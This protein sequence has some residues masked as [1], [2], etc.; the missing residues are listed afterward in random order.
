MKPAPHA[1]ISQGRDGKLAYDADERGNRV[2]DFSTC[3]YAGGDRKIP[4]APVRVVVSPVNGDATARIQLAIDYIASLAPD[5]NGLRGAVLL[6]KGRYEVF[7]GLT[8]TNSGVVLRGQ[9]TEN[10]HLIAT[11]LDRRTFIRVSRPQDSSTNALVSIVG[12]VPLNTINIAVVDPRGLRP[13][14]GPIRITRQ[15]SCNWIDQL[16]TTDFG[17]GVGGGWKAGARD[18]TWDRN[19]ITVLNKSLILD[20]PAEKVLSALRPA[21]RRA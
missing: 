1:I 3:G 13:L 10:T 5:S 8:I 20:A 11:D 4:D 2:P 17:G 16:R 21:W 9:G 7:G 6:L 18:V 12:D 14:L 15:S 19:V